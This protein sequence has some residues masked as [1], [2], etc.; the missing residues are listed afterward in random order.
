MKCLIYILFFFLASVPVTG[1]TIAPDLS[2][3]GSLAEKIEVWQGY[4]NEL[5]VSGEEQQYKLLVKEAQRGLALVP[6]DSVRVKAMFNLFAGVACEYTKQYDDAIRYFT[7]TATLARKLNKTTYEITALSRLDGIYTYINNVSARK[8]VMNRMVEIAASTQDLVAKELTENA[9]SGYYR[10]INDYEAAIKYKIRN[11]DTYKKLV[12]VDTLISAED[13][14][15]NMGIKLS[16]IGN[17]FNETG[18]YDKALEYLREAQSY[19]GDD[20]FEAN[21]ESLYVFMIQSF[22]GLDQVD[23]AYHY[24]KASYEK[25]AGRDTVYS[26]LTYINHFFG[27]YYLAKDN[28]DSAYYFAQQAYRLSR[29]SSYKD[30]Y[31]LASDLLGNVY[32]RQKKYDRAI[33]LLST[34]LDNDF[35]L[36][37]QQCA[38]LHKA[39]SDCYARLGRWDSAY[40]HFGIY[41]HLKDTIMQGIANKNFADAE[42]RFQNKEKR[43]LIAEKDMKL[44]A[45]KREKIWLIAGLFLAALSILLLFIIYRNRHRTARILEERNTQLSVLNQELDVANKTKAT[46]FGIISH[47][48]RA[49]VSQVYNFLK[50]LQLNASV[51]SPEQK[52]ELSSKI[53]DDTENLLETMENLLLWSKTQMSEFLPRYETIRLSEE[54]DHCKVL[55][56][57]HSEAKKISYIQEISPDFTVVTD[58]NFIATIIRNLLQNAVKASLTNGIIRIY[59]EKAQDHCVLTIENDGGSFTQQQYEAALKDDNAA[60]LSGLGL[61]LVATL[62]QKI[63]V[64][65]RFD[66]PEAH[67]V[68]VRLI[69][70]ER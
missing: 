34:A 62:A 23:S 58:R 32:F 42:A 13:A 15:T 5:L 48:L 37:K 65:I 66:E 35:R 69:I 19:I 27:E 31:I 38:D 56:Q 4:C 68:R 52:A 2:K 59:A 33:G 10:D 17:L 3:A 54:I 50:L 43:H 41:S 9:L 30:S 8:E 64:E 61:Q 7:L 21:E 39:L 60:N 46:L 57:S 49:P 44:D 16:N 51:L 53:Q 63:N 55:L 36:N 14:R 12:K 11:H 45:A 67:T 20:A 70:P 22:L 26:A 6:D 28:V 24:Y 40:V 25:M 47:D 18:Q 29:K 1:K